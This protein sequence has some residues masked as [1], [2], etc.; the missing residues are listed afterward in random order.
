MCIT[1]ND[2]VRY[3]VKSEDRF[4][5]ALALQIAHLWA[6]SMVAYQLGLHDLPQSVAFLSSI[7]VDT[8]VRTE[9]SMDCPTPSNP[10]GLKHGYGVPP[11]QCYDIHQILFETKG[12]LQR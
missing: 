12:T 11:G 5:A 3:L 10:H 7:R 8:V 9:T 1:I 6:S 4:R 2:Q